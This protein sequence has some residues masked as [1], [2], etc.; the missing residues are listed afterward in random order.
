MH[1]ISRASHCSNKHLYS[2]LYAYPI[3]KQTFHMCSS[4]RVACASL[5][6]G[7]FS[8]FYPKLANQIFYSCIRQWVCLEGFSC[9]P[10]SPMG[11][12]DNLSAETIPDFAAWV[13]LLRK[14]QHKVVLLENSKLF[15]KYVEVLDKFFGDM[16]VI[17]WVVMKAQELGWCVRR[18]RWWGTMVH[19]DVISGI[20]DGEIKHP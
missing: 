2:R 1:S 7:P 5:R 4:G 16:Y 20:I 17:D 12:Q 13:A 19:K 18:P 10:Y 14:V 6:F 15:A 8:C 9:T 3:T 11:K